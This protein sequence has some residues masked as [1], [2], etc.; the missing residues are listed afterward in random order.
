LGFVVIVALPSSPPCPRG[1][2]LAV[3]MFDANLEEYGYYRMTS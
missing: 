3:V 2:R 1:A